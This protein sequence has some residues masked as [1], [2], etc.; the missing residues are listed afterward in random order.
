M[1]MQFY[2]HDDLPDCILPFLGTLH[3]SLITECKTL[4]SHAAIRTKEWLV[5][6]ETC[7]KVLS[8]PSPLSPWWTWFTDAFTKEKCIERGRNYKGNHHF[9][10]INSMQSWEKKED[11]YFFHTLL[12][13]VCSMQNEGNIKRFSSLPLPTT[14]SEGCKNSCTFHLMTRI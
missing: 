6:F 2:C 7:S 13:I 5:T 3:S 14:T 11:H 1:C 10:S 9:K 12:L 4:K 8:I